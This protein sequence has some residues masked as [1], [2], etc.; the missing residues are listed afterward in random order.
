LVQELATKC[1]DFENM[2][3]DSGDMLAVT[4]AAYEKKLAKSEDMLAVTT[5]ECE[6]KLANS[7][8]MLAVTTEAY[9]LKQWQA[10]ILADEKLKETGELRASLAHYQEKLHLWE[11]DRRAELQKM[12]STEKRLMGTA[13]IELRSVV[14][15]EKQQLVQNNEEKLKAQVHEYERELMQEQVLV[16]LLAL[17]PQRCLNVSLRLT[18]RS[19]NV[20]RRFPERSKT[21]PEFSRQAETR[22]VESEVIALKQTEARTLLSPKNLEEERGVLETKESKTKMLQDQVRMSTWP[23]LAKPSRL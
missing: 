1:K 16:G 18:G 23:R 22:E 20:S 10:E 6:K 12:R 7:D 5:E 21:F 13:L 3:A 15:S 14:A 17:F 4:T 19:L 8:A 11:E 2:L 9:E